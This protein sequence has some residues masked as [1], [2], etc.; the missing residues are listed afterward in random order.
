MVRIYYIDYR[1]YIIQ[2]E[3]WDNLDEMELETVSKEVE[4]QVQRK[5][6]FLEENTPVKQVI[7]EET[8]KTPSTNN[9]GPTSGTDFSA[10]GTSNVAFENEEFELEYKRKVSAV[11]SDQ[12]LI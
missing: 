2:E 12:S 3:S 1:L 5:T 4:D 7:T 11:E 6:K 9:V 8:A 10:S